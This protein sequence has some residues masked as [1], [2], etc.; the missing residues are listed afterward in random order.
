M[1]VYSAL[2]SACIGIF[3]GLMYGLSFV[4]QQR[5]VFRVTASEQPNLLVVSLLSIVRF[6]IL[7]TLWYYLLRWPSIDFIL[8]LMFFLVT[9]WLIILKKRPTQDE[10]H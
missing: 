9:F 5:R 2:V 4:L 10:G 1:A 7:A 8:V 3:T 6:S